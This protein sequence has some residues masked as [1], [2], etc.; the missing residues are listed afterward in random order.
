MMMMWSRCM[1]ALMCHRILQWSSTD[2]ENLQ[3]FKKKRTWS[4]HFL[5]VIGGGLDVTE[6]EDQRKQTKGAPGNVFTVT[7]ASLIEGEVQMI[8]AVNN[9]TLRPTYSSKRK[10]LY[11][12]SQSS[13]MASVNRR[14]RLL[15]RRT[16]L[17]NDRK[18]LVF[19]LPSW[20]FAG[21]TTNR[22][23]TSCFGVVELVA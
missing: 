14:K 19:N 13:Q 15:L 16:T 9:T 2:Q 5:R 21:V 20:H 12:E 10:L 22:N 6:G 17:W 7:P 4:R 8:R 23:T 11:R 1:R 18:I 3:W